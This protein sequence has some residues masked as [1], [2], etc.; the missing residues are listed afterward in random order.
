VLL[1]YLHDWQKGDCCLRGFVLGAPPFGLLLRYSSHNFQ[2]LVVRAE[3]RVKVLHEVARSLSV[4]EGLVHP[5]ELEAAEQVLESSNH[6][7]D[8]PCDPLDVLIYQSQLLGS[9]LV[10]FSD[11][12]IQIDLPVFARRIITIVRALY[13]SPY[14]YNKCWCSWQSYRSNS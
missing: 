2:N 3:L 12:R 8:R 1:L 13:W 6:G 9:W 4:A 7:V 10:V 11:P 14:S 5:H